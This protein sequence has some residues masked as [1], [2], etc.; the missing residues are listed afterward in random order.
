MMYDGY[1][2]IF[3]LCLQHVCSLLLLR[4]TMCISYLF[5]YRVIMILWAEF[6]STVSNNGKETTGSMRQTVGPVL[7]SSTD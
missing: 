1:T 7:S 5:T 4:N 6:M 2:K 3:A